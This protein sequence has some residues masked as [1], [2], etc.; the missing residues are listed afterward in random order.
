[1]PSPGATQSTT[2]WGSYSP[3]A[4]CEP[5]NGTTGWGPYY[6]MVFELRSTQL[7][8]TLTLQLAFYTSL[9]TRAPWRCPRAP[10]RCAPW[11]CPTQVEPI[12]ASPPKDKGVIAA[13]APVLLVFSLSIRSRSLSFRNMRTVLRPSLFFKCCLMTFL[14]LYLNSELKQFSKTLCHLLFSSLRRSMSASM[15]LMLPDSFAMNGIRTL[16]MLWCPSF[17]VLSTCSI[18]SAVSVVK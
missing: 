4:E 5:Q 13:V 8:G 18:S 11:R 7:D 14:W 2:G 15:R 1:M 17:T 9:G 12:A 10:W 3:A 16:S 6:P